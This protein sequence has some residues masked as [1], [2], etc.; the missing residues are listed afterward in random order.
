MTL[1]REKRISRANSCLSSLPPLQSYSSNKSNSTAKVKVI[2]PVT[3]VKKG[4]RGKKVCRQCEAYVPIHSQKCH[5]C[6]FMFHLNH[7]PK[8]VKL[9]SLGDLAFTFRSVN[10]Q[11]GCSIIL[12]KCKIYGSSSKVPI[13][14]DSASL[15]LQAQLKSQ[16]IQKEIELQKS[17]EKPENQVCKPL[18]S[19]SGQSVVRG[20]KC[21]VGVYTPVS[22]TE[23]VFVFEET[24]KV[25]KIKSSHGML[26]CMTKN[27]ENSTIYILRNAKI[28]Y[29]LKMTRLTDFD[30]LLSYF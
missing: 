6:S 18:P 3:Q 10:W 13:S 22:Q 21:Q 26:F 2:I 16:S 15:E 5:I 7:K 9:P 20:I 27:G 4:K 28:C 19:H 30:C 29:Q 11:R 23:G 12:D 14:L 8:K 1:T 17:T 24:T 25:Q